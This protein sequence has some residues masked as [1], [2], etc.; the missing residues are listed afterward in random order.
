VDITKLRLKNWPGYA[1]Y[2]TLVFDSAARG[3]VYVYGGTHLEKHRSATLRE[4]MEQWIVE[5]G[6]DKVGSS[7]F[8]AGR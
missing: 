8:L 7:I 2:K 3:F 6:A 5:S 4:K 1:V